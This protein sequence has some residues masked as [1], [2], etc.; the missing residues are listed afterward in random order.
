M[1]EGNQGKC[2]NTSRKRCRSSL[3]EPKTEKL[4]PPQGELPFTTDPL[5]KK[6]EANED[7]IFLE[8]G[9]LFKNYY[10]ETGSFKYHQNI[11]PKQLLSEE[12]RSLHGNIGNHPTI[13][14]TLVAYRVK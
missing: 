10:G 5:Y 2:A 6:H 13:T 3:E 8:E 11:I 14:K 12:L 9:L 1:H 7:R 4:R